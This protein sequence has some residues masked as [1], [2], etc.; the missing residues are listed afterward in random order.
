MRFLKI[1]LY[2]VLT[3]I[4]IILVAGLLMSKSYK[5]EKEV[6]INKSKTEVFDFLKYL[7]N[8]DKFSYWATLDSNM[9]KTYTGTDGTIGF[10]SAWKGNKDVGQGEQEIAEI[11]EG[12]KI[13]YKLRFKE[14]MESEMNSYISTDSIS[15][16]STKVKW[17]MYGNSKY[18]F[19]V[20]NPFMDQMMGSD[21]QFGLDK[22]KTVLEK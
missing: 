17:A 6:T 16:T 9:Q 2:T 7:K 22:L 10:V 18:P 14:P 8:Q 1:V 12:E 3:I 20:M 5:L 21:I 15:P 13:E 19:N 11:K 4:A